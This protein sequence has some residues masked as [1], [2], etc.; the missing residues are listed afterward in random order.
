MTKTIKIE[1]AFRIP[2]TQQI[3]ESGSL[4]KLV[5]RFNN[6]KYS[7]PDNLKYGNLRG[8]KKIKTKK[9]FRK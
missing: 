9:E 8:I 6:W 5:E 7:I 3:I 1:N 4:I 2:G